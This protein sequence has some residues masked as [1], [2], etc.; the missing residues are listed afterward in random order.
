MIYDLR[1][2]VEEDSR[3]HED[4]DVRRLGTRSF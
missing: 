2:R 4:W 3:D 1:R